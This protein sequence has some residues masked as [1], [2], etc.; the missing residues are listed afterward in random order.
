MLVASRSRALLRPCRGQC[1]SLLSRTFFFMVAAVVWA[2]IA[3]AHV[4]GEPPRPEDFWAAWSLDPLVVLPLAAAAVLYGRGLARRW[5]QAGIG[6]GVKRW[7]AATFTGGM[8]AL[9]IALVWPLDP[10][11]ESLFAA[12]M[13]QHVVL[14]NIAAPLLVVSGPVSTMAYALPRDLRRKVVLTAQWRPLRRMSHLTAGVLA[15]TLLQQIALWI[16]HTPS[17]IEVALRDELVHA[18][19][20]G[21]LFAAALLF[22]A[23]ISHP[24][25]LGYGRSILAL[26]VTA[27]LSGLLGAIL[28]FAPRALYPVYVGRGEPWGLSPLEDQ[29][30]AGLMMM[31]SGGAI[32]LIA[33]TVLAALWLGRVGH[34]IP[35]GTAGSYPRITSTR[36]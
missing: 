8:I 30:L 17:A 32:Y 2:D 23:A 35:A 10:M 9:L 12:H 26:L 16:W 13:A 18:L 19:M 34:P 24:R 15:A 4:T 22:W 28:I 5:A 6:R 33:A 31:P 20:H 14:M 27:K 21:S 11:G 1:L 36:D 29:Q 3:A 25:G 7:Q